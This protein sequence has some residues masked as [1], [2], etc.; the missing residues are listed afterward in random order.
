M[1]YSSRLDYEDP[2]GAVVVGVIWV[3]FRA[4]LWCYHLVTK[5][6]VTGGRGDPLNISVVQFDY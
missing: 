1:Q 3:L 6:Y 4:L 5:M 2:L